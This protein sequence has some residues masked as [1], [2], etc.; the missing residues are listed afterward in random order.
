MPARYLD[1]T[2]A[3]LPNS[4][5]R[6]KPSQALFG[7]RARGDAGPDSD[8]DFLVVE[9]DPRNRHAEMVRLGRALRPLGMPFDVIVVSERYAEDWGA[10]EGTMVHAALTEGRV[11]HAVA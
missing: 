11:L 9:R 7:S 2:F 4:N 10:V 6:Y 1:P 8:F 5:N 3:L